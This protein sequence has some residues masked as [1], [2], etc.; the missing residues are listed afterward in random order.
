MRTVFWAAAIPGTLCVLIA[1]LG[2]RETSSADDKASK[3]PPRGSLGATSTTASMRLRR[4][5]SHI[6]P[7]AWLPRLPASFYSVL[8]AV[9]LFSLGNSSD[10]FLVL[11]AESIG[12]PVTHA[13][14]LGLVFNI[15]YTLLSWPAGH[16]SDRW[17]RRR[18]RG[19]RLYAVFAAVYFVFATGTF[20]A[21]DLDHH[22]V[23]WD[24]LRAH[25]ARA[26]SAGRGN[27]R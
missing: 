16:L 4:Q 20:A 5:P 19:H 13:P 8:G 24:V 23:V 15:T 3:H 11:R 18:D 6:A 27:R 25:R 1:L 17:P 22:G 9:T 2:I 7:G 21:G 10:M 14:L 26:E 12:I